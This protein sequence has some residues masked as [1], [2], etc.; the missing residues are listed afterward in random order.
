M[1]FKKPKLL[2]NEVS[3]WFFK[4]FSTQNLCSKSTE[5]PS[6]RSHGPFKFWTS[7]WSQS[8]NP[9]YLKMTR[10][11]S[12]E[13]ARHDL[14][15]DEFHASYSFNLSTSRSWKF[16][17]IDCITSF[18]EKFNSGL[19][20]NKNQLWRHQ[21]ALKAKGL[22]WYSTDVYGFFSKLDCEFTFWTWN[23]LL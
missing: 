11:L 5:G 4:F 23:V 9:C 16:M 3:K 12:R 21:S 20:T 19:Q 17:K 10:S 15:P 22:A 7:K 14:Y 8:N 6:D 2:Q 1:N 13:P 18:Y